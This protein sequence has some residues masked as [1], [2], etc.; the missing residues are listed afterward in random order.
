MNTNI[1]NEKLHRKLDTLT[2]EVF[3]EITRLLKE[4]KMLQEECNALRDQLKHAEAQVYNGKT[5]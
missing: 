1:N 3:L 4:N 5:F 2:K